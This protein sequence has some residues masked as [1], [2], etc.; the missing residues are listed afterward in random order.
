[1]KHNFLKQFFETIW[2]SNFFLLSYLT[3]TIYFS[4]S[5]ETKYFLEQNIYFQK[6]VL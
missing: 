6:E 2:L 3:H 1:M 4:S 5:M